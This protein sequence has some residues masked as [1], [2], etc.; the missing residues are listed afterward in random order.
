MSGLKRIVVTV[1]SALLEEVD[2][3]ALSERSNRSELVREAL[4]AYLEQKKRLKLR[5]QMMRGYM[6]MAEI[7]LEIAEQWSPELP[8]EP[9]AGGEGM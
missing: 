5:E 1:P 8:W 3:V 4:R 2:G 6:E 7:N 9:G